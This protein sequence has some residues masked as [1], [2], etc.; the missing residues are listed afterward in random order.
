VPNPAV[1]DASSLIVLGKIG[2]TPLLRLAG[3]PVFV[4]RAVEQESLAGGPADP[5]V[6]ALSASN[7][8]VVV[9]VGAIDPAI[10]Q[11]RVGAGEAEVLSWALTQTGTEAVIDD[12]AARR[13]AVALGAPWRGCVALVLSAK[14]HGLLSAARPVLEQ[15]RQAGFHLS[16]RT[17]NQ[18]LKLVGE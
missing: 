6:K 4:P 5:A 3:D 1:A 18:A 13:C 15:L 17:M 9:D 7:W 8:L 10:G 11:F 12:R 14:R 16:E 2:Q